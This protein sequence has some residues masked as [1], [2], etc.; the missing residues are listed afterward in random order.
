MSW[1][2]CSSGSAI[3]KAGKNANA[4]IIASSATLA[5]WSSEVEG[6]ICAF[7]RHD[8][9]TDYST[10]ITNFKTILN[11]TA[12]DLIAMKIVNY[13]M[14]GYSKLLEA[15]TMLDVL[16]D[17]ASRNLTVLSNDDKKA[18]MGV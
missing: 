2:L 8:W 12:S 1:T 15:E 13:D 5:E 9:I 17:N 7:T 11:D 18:V 16:R 4:T 14:S 10:V 6:S 3:A